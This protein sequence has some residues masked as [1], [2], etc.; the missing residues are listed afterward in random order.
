MGQ[1]SPCI[2]YGCVTDED[3]VLYDVEYKPKY[4]ESGLLPEYKEATGNEPPDTLYE[5]HIP[6][7]CYMVALG[8]S[9]ED[10][11]PQIEPCPIDE[12]TT[13]YAES[14]KNAIVKWKDFSDWCLKAKGVKL[15]HPKLYLSETVT[16]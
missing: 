2:V 3:I 4:N 9:G 13:V 6:S 5:T 16:A 15:P 8:G 11:V 12:I 14:Y 7:I 10:S 1:R